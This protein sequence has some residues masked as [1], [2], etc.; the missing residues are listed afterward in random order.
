M[1]TTAEDDRELEQGSGKNYFGHEG[2]CSPALQRKSDLCTP[3]KKLRGLS[4]NFHIH[5]SVRNLCIPTIGPPIVLQQ[6][7]Q[8]NRRKKK[9]EKKIVGRIVNSQHDLTHHTDTDLYPEPEFVNF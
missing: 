1:P 8:T 3:E 5:V 7:R 4:P 6:N 2:V 9:K